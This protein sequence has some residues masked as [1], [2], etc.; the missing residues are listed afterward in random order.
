[1]AIDHW[2]F[3]G[4]SEEGLA[5]SELE[6]RDETKVREIDGIGFILVM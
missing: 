5:F 4:W 2:V 1:M 6:L 3:H